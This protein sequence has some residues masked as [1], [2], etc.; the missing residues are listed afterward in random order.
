MAKS[1][2]RDTLSTRVRNS[3][4]AGLAVILPVF[5]TGAVIWWLFTRVVSPVTNEVVK[6][7][8]IGILNRLYPA[9]AGMWT[10]SNPFLWNVVSV[11]FLVLLIIL[12][13]VLARNFLG[14][15]IIRLG[16]RVLASIPVVR[17][18]YSTMRQ[19]SEALLGK[20]KTAFNR[21]VL[22]EYPRKGMY[23]LGL[24][25]GV[26]RAELQRRTGERLLNVFVPTTPNPT[27][28]YLLMVPEKDTIP[29]DMSVTEGFKLLISAGALGETD[30][31]PEAGG[32]ED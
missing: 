16:E 9:K 30:G 25:S 17:S 29:L 7:P 12:L 28:G 18:V 13:G 22:I 15:R 6:R 3:F 21:V 20:D 8:I 2:G 14:R 10:E 19:V 1:E 31:V 27:S 4:L 5:V 32:V 11:V 24:V 26:G 23:T